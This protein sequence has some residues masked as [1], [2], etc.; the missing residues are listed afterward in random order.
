MRALKGVTARE[1]NKALQRTGQRFWQE[2]SFDHWVRSEG[3]FD[4][5]VLYIE[6]NPVRAGLVTK[7]EDWPWSSAYK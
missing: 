1:A 3:S 2:E 5:I 6:N 7:P 4:R